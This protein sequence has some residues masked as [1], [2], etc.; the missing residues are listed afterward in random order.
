MTLRLSAFSRKRR[1]LMFIFKLCVASLISIGVFTGAARADHLS[2]HLLA[3]GAPEKQLAGIHLEQSTIADVIKKYG[4]PSKIEKQPAPSQFEIVDY[5]WDL[6][7]SRLHVLVMF[8]GCTESISLIE[9]EDSRSSKKFAGT[10]RGLKI[11]DR[12][13]D[14]RRI[15]GKRYAVRHIPRQKIHDVRLEWRDGGFS[16]VS[17]LNKTGRI[18]KLSLI[19]PE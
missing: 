7:Q 8:M 6:A 13:S 1:S 17:E 15:Y 12:L 3:R 2:E 18:K 14:L 4:K 11:G 10:G 9:V 5:Y 16:L 19:A